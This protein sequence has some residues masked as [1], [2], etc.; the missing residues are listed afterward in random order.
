MGFLFQDFPSSANEL[1]QGSSWIMSGNVVRQDGKSI[2][3]NYGQLDLDL[4][5]VNQQVPHH[6]VLFFAIFPNLER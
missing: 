1:S 6:S 3:E 5:Q 2:H 4:D